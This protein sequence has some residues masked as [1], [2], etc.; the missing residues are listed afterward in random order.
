MIA[1]LAAAVVVLLALALPPADPPEPAPP[2]P[3]SA[4]DQR[5]ASPD[6]TPAECQVPP[7]WA[8][9]EQAR[10]CAQYWA[11]PEKWRDDCIVHPNDPPALFWICQ[12]MLTPGVG[13]P[14]P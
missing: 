10:Q 4:L 8:T 5:I 11:I 14:G 7:P 6:A 3:V 2:A 13:Y 1:K 12:G 9:L